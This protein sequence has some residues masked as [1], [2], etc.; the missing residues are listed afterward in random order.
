M[1]IKRKS[2]HDD[3]GVFVHGD[4]SQDHVGPFVQDDSSHYHVGLFVHD[5]SS[6]IVFP[7][8]VD[9]VLN[10][11]GTYESILVIFVL[12]WVV[13]DQTNDDIL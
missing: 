11:D 5:V 3:I 8:P 4:I 12:L 1:A 9:V 2:I 7:F 6:H 10:E 13:Q